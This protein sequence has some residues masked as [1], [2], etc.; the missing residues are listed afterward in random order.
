MWKKL[1]NFERKVFIISLLIHLLTAY[2]SVGYHQPDEYFQVYEF[3]AWKLGFAPAAELP[4]EFGAQ[5]RGTVQ[6]LLVYAISQFLLVF[7]AFQPA[8]VALFFRT[9]SALGAWWAS[10][11]LY[12]IAKLN[13]ATQKLDRFLLLSSVFLWFLTYQSVR[14]SSENWSALFL[15]FGLYLLLKNKSKLNLAY[16]MAGVLFGIS[17]LFRFQI[18]FALLGLGAWLLFIQKTTYR[19]LFNLI[20]GGI[21]SLLLGL[22]IDRWFYGNWVFTPYNYFVSNILDGNAAN[23]GVTPWY[24]YFWQIFLTAVPPIS[25][26]ILFLAAWAMVKNPKNIFV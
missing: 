9:I 24:D 15:I 3:A 7:N 12:D 5:I 20:F 23:F 13:L 11:L 19:L 26:A 21:L 16:L 4:W 25:I 2:F 10:I 22:L 17:F 1:D 6:P 18:A 8:W 14:F